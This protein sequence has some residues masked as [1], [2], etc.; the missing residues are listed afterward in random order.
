MRPKRSGAFA[1]VGLLGALA[2]GVSSLTGCATGPARRPT[3]AAAPESA[4]VDGGNVGDLL[5]SLDELEAGTPA[6]AALRARVSAFVAGRAL[7]EAEAGDFTAALRLTRT[8]LRH[9]SPDELQAGHLPA[10]LRPVAE[11]LLAWASP[12]GDEATSLAAARILM[13]VEG[14][15]A[16]AQETFGRIRDWGVSNRTEFY[17]PWVREAALAEIWSTVAILVPSRDVLN[18]AAEHI[19]A[20]RRT[21]IEGRDRLQQSRSREE[22]SRL[23]YDE[24]RQ[25][26][27]G[28]QA[29]GAELAVL[30]LRVGELQEA[31]NRLRDLGTGSEAAN[32]A[33]VL[34]SIASGEDG[35]PRMFALAE[36]LGVLE[37]GGGEGARRG[38]QGTDRLQGAAAGVCRI[39]RRRY[40]TD[41]RFATCLAQDAV[42]QYNA[43]LASAHLERAWE[44]RPDA[45]QGLRLALELAVQ[46][47]RTELGAEDPRAGQRAYARAATLIAEWSRRY[48]GQN[49]PVGVADLEEFAA[50]LS[51][52]AGDLANTAAHLERATAATPASREAYLILAELHLRRRETAP[53]LEALDRGLRLPL[54]PSES[55]SLFR[56]LFQLRRAQVL[57]ASGDAA[58]ASAAYEEVARALD[59][60]THTSSGDE[61]AALLLERATVAD[62]LGDQARVRSLLNEALDAAPEN[63]DVYARAVTFCLA[64]GRWRDARDLARAARSQ[65]SLD[66]PWQVYFGLWGMAAS[67][68]GHLDDDGGARASLERLL[69]S[70]GDSDAWTLQLARRYVGALTRERV[71][72]LARTQGQRAEFHFYDAML[73]RAEGDAAGVEAAL[74]AVLATDVM[75]YFEYEMAWEMLA[76][77][78]P[79]PTTPR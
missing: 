53:A 50:Q 11:R 54:R 29:S 57:G 70:A 20:R 15:N 67:G 40:P 8:A 13:A 6:Y 3:A 79:R 65:L 18:T 26:R 45:Q 68:A 42:A 1:S 75:R 4:E 78:A 37:H 44:L 58:A 46:W 52:G 7:A 43:A 76:R 74:R 22:A 49:P 38:N 19:V 24:A 36:R 71:E 2:L 12:R 9:F 35:A 77:Q 10:A 61:L 59:A 30:Y 27:A 28:L 16:E 72:A 5:R 56:P 41:E 48:P 21:A 69:S 14:G 64:R 33:D 63:R 66:R 73:K 51:L 34:G 60:L 32:L 62:A 55:D 23:S 25:L 31:A 17:R 39:G 47:L